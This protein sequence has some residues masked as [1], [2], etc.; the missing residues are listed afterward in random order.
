MVSKI[1]YL[2]YIRGF[3]ETLIIMSFSINWTFRFIAFS[4]SGKLMNFTVRKRFLARKK[5]QQIRPKI[6]I[7]LKNSFIWYK[8]YLENAIKRHVEKSN[9]LFFSEYTA[10]VSNGVETKSDSL[11]NAGLKLGKFRRNF[12]LV[13]FISHDLVSLKNIENFE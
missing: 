2:P 5:I 1:P 3:Y 12:W 4:R 6:F 10:W 13:I 11:K 9:W 8:L 7:C